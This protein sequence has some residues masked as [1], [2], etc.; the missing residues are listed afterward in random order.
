MAPND[1]AD[2]ASSTPD[3][4]RDDDSPSTDSVRSAGASAAARIIGEWF[5]SHEEDSPG[6]AVY[7]PSSFEF[8]RARMPRES[9]TFS[10]GGR[11]AVGAPG[12]A[13]R[14]DRTPGHWSL[15]G[16]QIVVDAGD[17]PPLRFTL[18]EQ[19]RAAPQL[20]TA[21]PEG[22]DHAHQAEG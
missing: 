14:A 5:H 15:V 12:P 3:S 20:R 2:S 13:D 17:G 21:Q 10:A 8:P 19:D 11:A 6:V 9:I 16:E 7:R 22:H 18:D 1:P 4:A